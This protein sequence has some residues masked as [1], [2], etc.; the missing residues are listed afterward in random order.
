MPIVLEMVQGVLKMLEEDAAL[1][2]LPVE[3]TQTADAN[4]ASCKCIKALQ[5]LLGD[6]AKAEH[7][8]NLR[9]NVRPGTLR[10]L[11]ELK[12]MRLNVDKIFGIIKRAHHVTWWH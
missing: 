10:K 4:D 7:S 6:L 1:D 12:S 11:G 2:I 9:R 5:K 3:A 8:F